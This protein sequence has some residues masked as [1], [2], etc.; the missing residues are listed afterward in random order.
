[1]KDSFYV[2]VEREGSNLANSVSL[3]GGTSI[4]QNEDMHTYLTPGN[5]FCSQN[6]VAGTLKNCPL[7]VAFYLKVMK[8]SSSSTSNSYVLHQYIA[9]DGSAIVMATYNPYNSTWGNVRKVT[10]T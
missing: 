10:I 9:I 1:M 8:L 2:C 7:N 6:A 4:S 5:Y 3:L